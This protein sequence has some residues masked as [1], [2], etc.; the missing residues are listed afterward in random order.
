MS[1]SFSYFGHIQ[2]FSYLCP[3]FFLTLD[4]CHKFLWFNP[5]NCMFI[6]H[7]HHIFF[8]C[9][10]A[11]SFVDITLL[12]FTYVHSVGFL[13]TLHF[14]FLYMSIHFIFRTLCFCFWFIYGS[15]LGNEV[16]N[17]SNGNKQAPGCQSTPGGLLRIWRYA[18]IFL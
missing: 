4:I 8:I 18:F 1:P 14:C 6:E 9:P 10:I 16:P 13:W 5:K 7:F 12:F 11:L 17:F 2:F 3:W 15:L